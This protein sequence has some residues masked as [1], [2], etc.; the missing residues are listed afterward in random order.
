MTETLTL[1]D[2]PYA[3]IWI[4]AKNW[5]RVNSSADPY[6]QATLRHIASQPP[7]TA[8]GENLVGRALRPRLRMALAQGR[9]DLARC[10]SLLGVSERTFQRRLNDVGFS[11][12]EIIDDFRREE[13]VRLLCNPGLPLVEVASRLGYP[14]QTSFKRYRKVE[15]M[16]RHRRIHHNFTRSRRYRVSGAARGDPRI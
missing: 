7:T 9:A 2:F 6:L 5:L 4:D 3:E 10:A 12:S 1:Y 8:P 15:R 11:L 14:E 16:W 13:S